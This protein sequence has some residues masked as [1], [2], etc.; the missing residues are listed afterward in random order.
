MMIGE[1]QSR[2]PGRDRLR[3]AIGGEQAE[4]ER[5]AGGKGLW[6]RVLDVFGFA[7]DGDEAEGVNRNE[8]SFNRP[9]DPLDL[10]RRRGHRPAAVKDRPVVA[11]PGGAGAVSGL[12]VAVFRPVSLDDARD[13]ADQLKSHRPVILNL[14]HADRD[15]RQRILDFLSGVL[16][17]VDGAL[18]QVGPNVLLLTPSGVEVTGLGAMPR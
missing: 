4:A 5:P 17:T 10:Y 1:R 11:L 9:N 14:E 15:M 3:P 12:R 18:N 6:E 2:V 8:E 16:Y 7:D 13:A